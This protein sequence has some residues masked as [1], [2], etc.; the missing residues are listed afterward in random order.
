MA[1]PRVQHNR[2]TPTGILFYTFCQALPANIMPRFP[3]SSTSMHVQL[4]CE[5]AGRGSVFASS[6]KRRFQD[7]NSRLSPAA[8]LLRPPLQ[9]SDQ[10]SHDSAM[11]HA[12]ADDLLHDDSMTVCRFPPT[13]SNTNKKLKNIPHKVHPSL[14]DGDDQE[15]NPKSVSTKPSVYVFE[16]EGVMSVSKAC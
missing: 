8:L 11:T 13:H 9:G 10:H 5:G 7:C 6:D 15:T 3:M 2:N 14:S 16:E 1:K 12:W 4:G